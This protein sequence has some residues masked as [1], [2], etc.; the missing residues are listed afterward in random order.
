M[1][2]GV[3]RP[4]VFPG[5]LP[6]SRMCCA[7]FGKCSGASSGLAVVRSHGLVSPKLGIW[8]LLQR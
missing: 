6:E 4:V 5:R 1:F 2:L 7:S 8:C 3:S